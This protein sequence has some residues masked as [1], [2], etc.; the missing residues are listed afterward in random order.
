VSTGAIAVAPR[1]DAKVIAL[2]GTGHFFSHFYLLALPPLF[3]LLKTEFGVSYA[4]LGAVITIY[5]LASGTAQVPIGFL[6]DRVRARTVLFAGLAL[7][8]VA[9]AAIGVTST[10]WALLALI[11]VAGLGN[12]VF[13]PAD[14]AILSATVAKKRLGRAFSFHTFA[15]YVG[16]AVA[17]GAMILMT[18]L[19][20]WRGA[21]VIAGIVGFTVALVML[22]WRGGLGDDAEAEVEPTVK[23]PPSAARSDGFALLLSPPMLMFFLFYVVTSMASS[24]IQTFSVA[25][26]VALYDTPLSSANAALTGFLVAGALGILAGGVIVD[27]TH[28]ADIITA[29]GYVA[30]AA[31]VVVVAIMPLPLLMLIGALT[32]AGLV[33]GVTRPARDMMV[34]SAT[35]P[36]ST[37]KV[38]GFVSTGLNVGGA[39]SPVLFGWVIDQG[40]PR[41][42]FWLAVLFMLAA[43][44]TALASSRRAAVPAE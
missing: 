25:A 7:N 3:P 2:V 33:Q 30:A 27:R 4:A 6:V 17:P 13:H 34:R 31:A 9:I 24:G 26:I 44:A 41:Y 22:A 42:V 20:G 29:I 1:R 12:S 32:I 19:W 40:E 37:G 21:L 14:Y 18:A 11:F 23:T 5:N 43:A 38:F 36:G 15:G 28:R 35:P 10:Y 8:A 16:F 39:V